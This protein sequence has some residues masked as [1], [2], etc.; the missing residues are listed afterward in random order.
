MKQ[1]QRCEEKLEGREGKESHYKCIFRKEKEDDNRG[2]WQ[3]KG[4]AYNFVTFKK[5]KVKNVRMRADSALCSTRLGT[6]PSLYAYP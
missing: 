2:P 5:F 6:K 4:G 1:C 3:K